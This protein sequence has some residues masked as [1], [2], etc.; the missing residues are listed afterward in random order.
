MRTSAQEV[1]GELFLKMN[2]FYLTFRCF[3][4][5][6]HKPPKFDFSRNPQMKSKRVAYCWK[7]RT[8]QKNASNWTSEPYYSKITLEQTPFK[9]AIQLYELFQIPHWIAFE[10]N[11]NALQFNEM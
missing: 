11:A 7:M 10:P 2:W 5:G 6:E 9:R 4:Y 1:S 8:Q 3:D